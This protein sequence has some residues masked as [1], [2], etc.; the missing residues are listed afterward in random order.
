MKQLLSLILLGG[1]VATASAAPVI[2][3]VEG[4]MYPGYPEWAQKALTP[5][6]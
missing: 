5:Q 6:E 3:T 4:A 2:D 1:F